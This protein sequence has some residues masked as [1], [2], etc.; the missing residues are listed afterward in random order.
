MMIGKYKPSQIRKAIVAGCT[1]FGT[2]G[3]SAL[4]VFTDYLPKPA[5]LAVVGAVGFAGALGVFLT[6][7]AKLID[8]ADQL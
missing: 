1:A 6:R 8:S 4:A 7:N 5:A 3:T 2:L